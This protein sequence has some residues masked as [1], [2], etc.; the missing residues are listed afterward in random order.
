MFA[1][2]VLA[3][4]LAAPIG[5]ICLLI[6]PSRRRRRVTGAWP[7]ARRLLIAVA[8]T[9]LLA[10]LVVGALRLLGVTEHNAIAGA[11]G[12]AVASLVWLPVT[13][14]WN[15]RGHLCWSIDDLPVRRVPGVRA[16]TGRSTATSGAA[17][18]AG[19]LLLWLFEVFAAAAGLRLPVGDL[20]RAGL[21]ALAPAGQPGGAAPVPDGE[22][23]FV[24]LHVPAHNEPPDMVIETLTL[25]GPAGL[26]ALRDRGHRRQHRRRGAVAAG[27]GLV[28]RARREV[29]APGGLAGLQVRRAELRA[30]AS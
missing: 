29:R 6:Q 9:V 18:T 19:G 28:R 13:R 30:D 4:I 27:P 25:A 1:A 12:L 20:R 15:A 21:R 3:G 11:A 14:R 24:S 5:T 26:P 23:P 7:S 22:L 16:A 2:L 17:G 8:G 10:G